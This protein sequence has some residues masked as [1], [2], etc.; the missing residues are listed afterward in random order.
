MIVHKL[1]RYPCIQ[2]WGPAIIIAA[3]SLILLRVVPLR[4]RQ[5]SRVAAL[6]S[7]ALTRKSDLTLG[8]VRYKSNVLF[9]LSP[10]P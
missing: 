6:V 1:W 3:P 5:A 4:F 2:E 8:R 10:A 9:T 7:L